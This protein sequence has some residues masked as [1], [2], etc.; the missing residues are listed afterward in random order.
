MFKLA[1]ISKTY[2]SY[3]REHATARE[4][5]I[6]GNAFLL[7]DKCAAANE[8]SESEGNKRILIRSYSWRLELKNY[9]RYVSNNLTLD[10]H[11]GM[12]P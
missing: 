12:T 11:V 9:L 8:L 10:V 7:L 4:D 1:E 6:R 3:T 2:R 5:E